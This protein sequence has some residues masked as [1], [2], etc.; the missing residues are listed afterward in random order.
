MLMIRD[1]QNRLIKNYKALP[2][3]K[4]LMLI[5]SIIIL[6]VSFFSFI[7]MQISFNIYNKQLINNSSEI[8]NLY[9][10][11][12]ENELRKI[13][14]L[15]F[16]ILSDNKIQGYINTINEEKNSYERYY[17]MDSIRNALLNQSEKEKYISSISLVDVS[18]NVYSFGNSVAD[19][20]FIRS[21]GRTI[22]I[23]L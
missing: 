10:T 5:L 4:K 12:I 20:N 22:K 6:I 14:K 2:I 19:Y 7:V 15:S 18:E 11:N 16:S 21:K 9:T 3:K 1:I 8:L 13:D 17:A 23:F